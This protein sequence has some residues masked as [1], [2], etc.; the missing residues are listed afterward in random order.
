MI[1][2]EK[3][4][5]ILLDEQFALKMSKCLS[6]QNQVEYLGHVVSSRGVEPIGS[7]IQAIQQW[8]IPLSTRALRSFLGLAGFYQC[9]IRGYASIAAPL[10]HLMTKDSFVWSLT[11]Q[12]AFDMLKEALT[13]APVLLL[14]NFSL[15][16][17][18]ETNVSEVGMGAVLSQN[19]HPITFFSKL[20]SPKVL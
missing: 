17:T 6:A 11:A 9:F 8:P 18:L 13:M 20:F 7:K 4:L 16:F 14:P 3:A 15:P 10:N 2:L 19:G 12:Q 1:H 5:W